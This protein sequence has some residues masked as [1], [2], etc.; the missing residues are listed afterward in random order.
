MSSIM[1]M[2]GLL[3]AFTIVLLN[4]LLIL[5][6]RVSHTAY[7]VN[8]NLDQNLTQQNKA[9]ITKLTLFKN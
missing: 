4:V 3:L 5:L 6:T 2:I 9:N 7:L 8:L 1:M